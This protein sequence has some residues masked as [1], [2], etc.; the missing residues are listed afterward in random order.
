M[1]SRALVPLALGEMTLTPGRYRAITFAALFAL[2]AIIVTGA[3]VRLTGS[4][5]GCEDWPGCSSTK[6]IDVSSKHAAIEQVNRLFTGLVSVAVIAA[7]LGSLVRVPKRRDLL[8]LSL[9][10]VGGVIAQIVL[11]GI[12]VLVDLHPLAV[13]GH[14]IVSLVLV[15]NAVLLVHRA[16][17]PDGGTAV[18]LVS[19]ELNR[20]ACAIGALTA[21]ALVTGTVVTGAG[22]HAGDEDVQRFGIA[23]SSA[24]RVHSVAVWLAV[25]AMVALAVRLRDRGSE[26]AEIAEWVSAWI[27]VALLQGAVGYIQ[28]FN[29]VPEL[30]V[31]VHVFGAT[32]L[33]S[34]T[35][36]FVLRTM[37][38]RRVEQASSVPGTVSPALSVS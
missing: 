12:T 28:Y 17:Q 10:L 30:L 6:L 33:W 38:L 22:P 21:V 7:V 29:D 15:T 32:V 18:R 14:M 23:I 9:G 16:S 19:P 8:W 25:A 3:A 1:A 13:Q 27:F 35:V 26:R 11:G 37:P 5:L 34:I 4:G 20:H 31:G 2:G 24:A 36:A